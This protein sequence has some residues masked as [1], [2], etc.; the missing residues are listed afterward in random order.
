MGSKEM[1]PAPKI[2]LIAGN[3]EGSSRHFSLDKGF[4][5][6]NN[7]QP[8]VL[9]DNMVVAVEELIELVNQLQGAMVNFAKEQSILNA[10]IALHT[11]PVAMV[12]TTPSPELAGAGINN[13]IKMMTDVHIP[14]FSQ[15]V[16][17]MFYEMNFLQPFGMQYINSRNVNIT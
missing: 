12:Y 17:T 2:E 5:T 15:K 9:G 1:R 3:Q 7:I 6:V 16:N 13:M 11:H 10:T 8:A 4:F 14:L